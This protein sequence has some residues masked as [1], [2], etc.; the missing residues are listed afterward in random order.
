[1]ISNYLNKAPLK[2]VIALVVIG[3]LGT[4]IATYMTYK[5]KYEEQV[6]YVILVGMS[7]LTFMIISFSQDIADYILLYYCLAVITLY[8]DFKLIIIEGVIV[9]LITIYFFLTYSETLFKE[10]SPTHM[11]TLNFY[12][13]IT[14]TVLAF[15]SKIGT[16][17]RNS[18]EESNARS[19][20]DNIKLERMFAQARKT[21]QTLNEF[22]SGLM[23]NVK[24][25]GE[26]AN[27]ITMAFS[28]IAASIDAQAQ[29]VSDINTSMHK[30]N[31]ELLAVSATSTGMR[32]L[33]SFTVE[34]VN[35]GNSEI[36]GLTAEFT[37]V[38]VNI[39]DTV[40][41]MNDLNEQTNQIGVILN[42]INEISSKTNLL[43]L[44]AAIE[45][46]RAGEHGKGFGIVADEVKKLAENSRRSTEE[47]ALILHEVQEK[48]E[49]ATKKVHAVQD[50]FESSKMVTQNV[51]VAFKK[52]NENTDKVLTNA[53][54]VDAKLK[55]L[56]ENLNKIVGETVSISCVAE[57]ISASIEE[58]T[59]SM[60]EQNGKIGEIVDSFKQIE[61]LVH[62]LRMQTN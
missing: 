9:S 21:V 2:E 62:E 3:F 53:Q 30:S 14:T 5:R 34:T 39:D 4:G 49:N 42:T 28:Q 15:Q 48:V 51:A 47:I 13:I 40:T 19:R 32:T 20:E 45:A 10:L 8:H 29:S 35:E 37:K 25:M 23:K 55:S 22:S 56:Q 26:T 7:L 50:S 31:E 61:T 36:N 24:A 27:E 18:L 60:T 16:N 12:L 11:I 1:M 43:A 59:A 58:V 57:E 54:E 41:L 46:A 44:N 33:S 38:G 52:V 17:M 6:R